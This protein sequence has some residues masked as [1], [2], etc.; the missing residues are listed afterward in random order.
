MQR[1]VHSRG[2]RKVGRERSGERRLWALRAWEGGGAGA[3]AWAWDW[4]EEVP[5]GEM[6]VRGEKFIVECVA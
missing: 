5:G 6:R 3:W 2:R 1:T 4:R